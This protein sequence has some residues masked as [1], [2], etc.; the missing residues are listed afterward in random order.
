MGPEDRR[1]DVPR[2]SSPATLNR[3]H[4]G[5]GCG[6]IRSISSTGERHAVYGKEWEMQSHDNIPVHPSTEFRYPAENWNCAF[7][8]EDVEFRYGIWRLAV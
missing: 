5:G 2:F 1:F 7:P 6:P 4:R 8:I 3:W